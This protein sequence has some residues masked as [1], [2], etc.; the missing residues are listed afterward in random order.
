MKKFV[1]LSIFF[2]LIFFNLGVSEWRRGVS[3]ALLEYDDEK[4]TLDIYN[5]VPKIRP[6]VILIHGAAGIKGDRAIRYK[7]FA[8]D[9]MNRGII[10]INVHYFES[11]KQNWVKTIIKTIDY[12]ENIANADKSRIGIVGYSLGGT[13]ALKVAALDNRVSSLAISAGYLPGGF[14]KKDAVKLPKTYMISGSK[15]SAMQTLYKLKGWFS[16]LDKNFK[17]KIDEG[18]GHSVPVSIF[19]KDWQSIITFFTKSFGIN[20]F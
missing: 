7:K 11:K 13:L 16:E 12:A 4:V 1:S 20:Y 8:T 3:S 6:V 15:D 18:Y 17:Y 9:L 10:A 5:P 2:V 19:E 14:T